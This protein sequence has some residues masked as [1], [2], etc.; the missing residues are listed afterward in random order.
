[1]ESKKLLLKVEDVCERLSLGRSKV[2]EMMASGELRSVQVGRSRRVP[3]PAL[4]ELLA[5]L[6]Q[7]QAIKEVWR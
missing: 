4:D 1:M 6:E 3:A 7:D 5:R 2:Y